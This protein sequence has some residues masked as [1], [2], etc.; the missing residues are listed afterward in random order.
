MKA[1]VQQTE[2]KD[3]NDFIGIDPGLL[4]GIAVYSKKSGQFDAIT[5]P[6]S[7]DGIDGNGIY[8]FIF[9]NTKKGEC[10]AYIEKA[11]AMPKQGV[12]GIFTYGVGYGKILATLELMGIP[13]RLVRPAVWKRSLGL[14]KD[15]ADAVQRAKSLAPDMDLETPRGRLLDGKAEAMLIAYY[16]AHH[17]KNA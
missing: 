14:G 7:D 12:V 1:L 17:D 6:L 9:D 2:R 10:V 4:G 11:Q 5:M 13:V 16:G 15:K 8:E 3:F